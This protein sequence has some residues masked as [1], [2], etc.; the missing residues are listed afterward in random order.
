MPDVHTP[1]QR[2]RNMAAIRS[3]NTRPEIVVRTITHHLGYRY[4][5]HVRRLPGAPDLVFPRLRK[6]INVHGCYWHMHKCRFGSVVPK[7]NT[8]FWRTKRQGNVERDRRTLNALRRA[9]WRVL[10]V[11]ECQTQDL[12]RVREILRRFLESPSQD[13][14]ERREMKGTGPVFRPARRRGG[15]K[16]AEF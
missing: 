2:S 9:G 14:I 5:L 4:R 12:A 10:V 11:W 3:K 7:T 1:A 15:R 8:D 6:I 16:V 13:A